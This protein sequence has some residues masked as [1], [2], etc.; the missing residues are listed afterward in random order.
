MD[1]EKMYDDTQKKINQTSNLEENTYMK[2]LLK[3][4]KLYYSLLNDVITLY[5]ISKV[6]N[7][8]NATTNYTTKLSVLNGISK[9]IQ[10]ITTTIEDKV[11]IGD[12]SLKES[13]Q[14]TKNLKQMIVNLEKNNGNLEDLDLTS[15]RM[16]NDYITLYSTQRYVIWIKGLIVVFLLYI[17]FSDAIKHPELRIYVF[18]WMICIVM[19]FILQYLKTLMATKTNMP[20]GASSSAVINV[21]PLSCSNTE[22]GCCPDG[23]TT[24][25]K[26][27]MNCSCIKTKYGCCPDGTD[28][29]EDGNCSTLT[30]I[31]PIPCNQTEYGCCPDNK[32]ISNSYGSNCGTNR[33]RPPLCSNTQY[34]CCPDGHSISN[35]DRSNCV[36]SCAS[37]LYGCC[38]NGVTISNKDRSNCNVPIC[39]STKYGCCPNGTSRNQTGSNCK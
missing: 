26:N 18:G 12:A 37:S 21:N 11:T 3:Q 10:T 2:Q 5:P 27:G 31:E 24:K 30:G 16:L 29:P 28:K 13:Q 8:P 20:T 39:S 32:T 34:G 38:P 22:Y 4:D 19:L 6:K 9:T 15:K 23:K 33:T 25:N 17:L 14:E 35:V 1:I 36:G 7:T